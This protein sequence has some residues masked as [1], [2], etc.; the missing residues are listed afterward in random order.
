MDLS[1]IAWTIGSWGTF[2]A[3]IDSTA[4]PGRRRSRA[5]GDP[6]LGLAM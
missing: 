5:Y 4:R 6:V 2:G 1:D 3:F